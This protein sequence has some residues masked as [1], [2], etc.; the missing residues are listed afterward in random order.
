MTDYNDGKWHNAEGEAWPVH[1]QSMVARTWLSVGSDVE[2]LD[3]GSVRSLDW[4][5]EYGKTTAFRVVKAY[6][7]PRTFWAVGKHLHD[8]LADAEAFCDALEL[9]HPGKGYGDKSRIVKL[10]EVLE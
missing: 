1:A 10:I 7:E 9:D 5:S 2:R 3:F 4:S 8:T 6:R